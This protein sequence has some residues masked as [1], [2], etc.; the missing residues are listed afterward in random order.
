MD[1][2]SNGTG[3]LSGCNN[4]FCWN[5]LP[6]GV[7]RMTNMMC[8]IGTNGP[9]ITWTTSGGGLTNPQ[10]GISCTVN[11]DPSSQNIKATMNSEK[12]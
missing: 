4:S 1:Y 10:T 2:P 6:C 3:G 12:E 7:C 11:S 5:R 9:T 8:P